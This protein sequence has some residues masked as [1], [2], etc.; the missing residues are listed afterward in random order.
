MFPMQSLW[1]ATLQTQDVKA[2]VS[3]P[4]RRKNF[5]T[6]QELYDKKIKPT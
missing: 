5:F 1:A 2:N 6:A 4:Q 3:A